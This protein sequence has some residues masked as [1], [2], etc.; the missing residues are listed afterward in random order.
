[1]KKAPGWE[2]YDTESQ[3]PWNLA[4]MEQAIPGCYPPGSSKVPLPFCRDLPEL[5]SLNPS[6]SS[7]FAA[8]HS[9]TW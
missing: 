1:M 8:L 7:E 9:S 2:V 3:K 6:L 5:L 4:E